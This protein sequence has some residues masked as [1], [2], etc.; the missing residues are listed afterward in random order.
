MFS[1]LK[2]IIWIAG[3]AVVGYYVLAH[4]GYDFN[5]NYWNESKTLCQSKLDQCRKDLFK[6]GLEGAKEKCDW[7]CLDLQLLI[8][9]QAIKN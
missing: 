2:L 9:K 6:T 1:L 5:W 4:F 7:K 3:V 8:R